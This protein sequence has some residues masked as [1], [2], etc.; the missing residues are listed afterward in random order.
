MV[1]G[2]GLNILLVEDDEDHAGLIRLVLS[3]GPGHVQVKT[4]SS[5][6]EALEYL[7]RRGDYRTAAS[8]RPDLVL[9]DIRLPGISGIE[10]LRQIKDSPDLTDMPVV[11]LTSSS[12]KEDIHDSYRH[13]ANS[14]VIKPFG[15]EDFRRKLVSAGFYWIEVNQSPS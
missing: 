1:S 6:E 8:P 2:K 4:I 7:F 3:E 10:V 13:H 5:G 14:Y 15:F 12:L 9:L 11:M